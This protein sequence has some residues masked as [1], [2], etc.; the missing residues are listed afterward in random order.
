MLEDELKAILL[1]TF[2]EAD[3]IEVANESHLHAGH[4]SSPESGQSHFK[5]IVVSDAFTCMSRVQ[6]HQAVNQA[7]KLLF[8]KGLHALSLNLF[9]PVEYKNIS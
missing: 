2:P 1:K 6:R 3:L 5:V 9:S 4:F 7:V 8:D